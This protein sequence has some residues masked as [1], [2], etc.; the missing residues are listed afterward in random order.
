MCFQAGEI[1][2]NRILHGLNKISWFVWLNGSACELFQIEEKEVLGRPIS[3]I[4][5]DDRILNFIT[6]HKREVD[7]SWQELNGDFFHGEKYK[8]HVTAVAG[9][10]AYV[11]FRRMDG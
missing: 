8:A 2:W 10:S 11:I 5:Q 4:T 7:G 3:D 1:D 9:G 6:D